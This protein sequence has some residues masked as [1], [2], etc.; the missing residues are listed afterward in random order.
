MLGSDHTLLFINIKGTLIVLFLAIVLILAGY[1]YSIYPV[2]SNRRIFEEYLI[3]NYIEIHEDKQNDYSTILNFDNDANIILLGEEHG[4]ALNE[5]IEL[6]LF[7][8]LIT[9]RGIINYIGE[10]PYSYGLVLNEYIKSGNE[11]LL[12][13][14]F[15]SKE[16]SFFHTIENYYK[17]QNLYR[18]FKENKI[19]NDFRIIGIDLEQDKEFT[20]RQVE[21]ILMN[22]SNDKSSE[23]LRLLESYKE[24]YNKLDLGK[25][26]DL[27]PLNNIREEINIVVQNSTMDNIDRF[28]LVHMLKNLNNYVV[29]KKDSGANAKN[30]FRDEVM[31]DNFEA[32]RV[33]DSNTKYF[34]K[35]GSNHVLQNKFNIKWFGSYL[36][37]NDKVISLLIR[38]KNSWRMSRNNPYS[39]RYF[40]RID[41]PL[42]LMSKYKENNIYLF[43]L[44]KEGS[45]FKENLLFLDS[46]YKEKTTDYFEY[47]IIV[48]RGRKSEHFIK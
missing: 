11:R 22:Y 1:F 37:E 29:W 39:I 3:Q 8:Y 38:Y 31:Y 33:K 13:E 16:K 25:S 24:A 4:V 7:K 17:W 21:K 27:S 34:G 19:N 30:E 15:V 26:I 41:D 40:T 47:L 2:Y 12:E 35:F 36:S 28:S 10:F 45:P 32:L 43:N 18:F 42:L 9:E 48:N 5:F 23:L 44:D 20:Y 46:S 6:D 14:L